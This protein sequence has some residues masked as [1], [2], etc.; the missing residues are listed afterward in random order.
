MLALL[1]FFY[2]YVLARGNDHSKNDFVNKFATFFSW[3][4][5]AELE[6]CIKGW[7]LYIRKF[8]DVSLTEWK[9][10]FTFPPN[11]WEF[12]DTKLL[13][14]RPPDLGVSPFPPFSNIYLMQ[15]QNNTILKTHYQHF[16]KRNCPS[17]FRN[18]L[19]ALSISLRETRYVRNVSFKDVV[20]IH[21]SALRMKSHGN[22][23]ELKVY[24]NIIF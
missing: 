17:N 6:K 13:Q 9:L 2:T 15:G 23:I 10:L 16:L 18:L 20:H 5:W 19:V 14:A 4:T 11:W 24:S 1:Y 21:Q 7:K 12:S 22:F 3:P 8:M